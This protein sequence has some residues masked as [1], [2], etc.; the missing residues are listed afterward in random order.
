M[1]VDPVEDLQYAIEWYRD[2]VPPRDGCTGPFTPSRTETDAILADYASLIPG[3]ALPREIEWLWRTWNAEAFDGLFDLLTGPKL[4]TPDMSRHNWKLNTEADYLFPANLIGYCYE[5]HW[6]HLA[7]LTA[8][9]DD[10]PA[11][12]WDWGYGGSSFELR[13]ASLAALFRTS[14]E[15]IELR[16]TPIPT[17]QPERMWSCP[18]SNDP[19]F[20]AITER[21]LLAAG[22]ADAR[23]RISSEDHLDWPMSWR[24]ATGVSPAETTTGSPTHTV[25]ELIAA[26]RLG[27][28]TAR[29]HG[30]CRM[31]MGGGFGPGGTSLSL[32]QF[33]DA[34]GSIGLVLPEGVRQIGTGRDRRFEVHVEVTGPIGDLPP[35]EFLHRITQ[36]VLRGDHQDAEIASAEAMGA[37]ADA[38]THLPRITRI[39]IIDAHG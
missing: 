20:A 30:T 19:A 21:H 33:T 8:A 32:M 17:T 3:H 7:D 38:S 11:P 39:A 16:G 10:R 25:A 31:V 37:G 15:L 1:A 23:R 27:P 36:A 34:T 22:Y 12:L 9:A 2:V 6:F 18:R 4:N 5:S 35:D 29:L 28:L 24:V 13:H 14:T 26:S